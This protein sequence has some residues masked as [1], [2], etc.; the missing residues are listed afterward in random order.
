[1]GVFDRKT[2]PSHLEDPE[3]TPYICMGCEESL[4]VQYHSCPVCGGYDI[5]RTKWLRE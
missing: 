3:G 1:M 2:E 5:R 4:E